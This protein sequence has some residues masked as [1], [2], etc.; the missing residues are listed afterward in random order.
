MDRETYMIKKH[1]FKKVICHASS[2]IVSFDWGGGGG[3]GGLGWSRERTVRLN[4]TKKHDFK[5]VN[6]HAR[7]EISVLTEWGVGG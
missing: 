1:D 6:C 2:K 4:M 7:S 5:K 3:V